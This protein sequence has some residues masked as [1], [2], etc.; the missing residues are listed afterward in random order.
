[1]PDHWLNG[2]N[3]AIGLAAFLLGWYIIGTQINRRRAGAV[4]RQVRESLQAF[5]G[6]ATIR[7][8]GRTAFRIE[9]EQ[10]SPPFIRLSISGLL[11]PRETFLLWALGRLWGR[12]DWLLIRASLDGSV[13]PAFELYHPQ[14]RG[15]SDV[16]HEIRANGWQEE[17]VAGYPGLRCAAPSAD[18]RG[19]AREVLVG[20]GGVEV[21]RVGLRYEA[22]Q[23]SI[24]LPVPATEV[25]PTLRGFAVLPQVAR[26][27][28]ARGSRR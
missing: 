13:G 4:V 19:L 3:L 26:T 15:A 27:V 20:L 22:P 12:R 17:A 8:I 6:T 2:T 14:R 11:E 10:L 5:G 28:L 16:A 21:W 9:A 7:W 18:G 23:L 24:G 25:E 1:M